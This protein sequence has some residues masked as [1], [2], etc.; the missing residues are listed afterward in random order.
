MRLRA[1]FDTLKTRD[2]G[3]DS[4]F[5]RLSGS[6]KAKFNYPTNYLPTDTAVISFQK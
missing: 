1:F 2:M 6:Y 5:E 3:L 4:G